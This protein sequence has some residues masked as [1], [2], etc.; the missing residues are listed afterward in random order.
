MDPVTISVV[1]G[2]LE[3]LGD[4]MDQ[5][6]IRAAISP[7]I[8]ETNDCAHGIFHPETGETI[9]QGRIGLPVFLANMQFT[10]QNVIAKANAA[11][12]FNPGDVWILNDPY[13]GGTHLPDVN[14][15]APHFVGDELVALFAN[16]GHW[17]DIGGSVPGGWA[18]KAKSIHEEGIIIPA[19]KL[20]DRGR[21]NEPLVEMFRANVRLP[22]QIVGD[23]SAMTNVFEL[24]RQGLDGLVARYGLGTIRECIDEMVVTSERQMRSYVA[25]IPDGV[26]CSEEWLDNDGIE[27]TP[28]RT[29]LRL[30]VRGDEMWLDFAGTARA[31]TGPMN[32]AQNTTLSTVYVALKHVFPEV[33]V[34]GGTFRPVHCSIP[35][36]S[37]LAAQYP[38]PVGGYLEVVSRVLDLVMSALAQAIPDKVPAASFGTTGVVTIGGHHPTTDAYFVGVFPYPGGYGGWSGGDGLV[39]GTPPQSMANFVSL[40]ASEHRYPIRFDHFAIREQSGGAGEHRGGCGTSYGFR[41]WGPCDMSVL[42]DRADHGPAGVAGG[43]DAAANSVRLIVDDVEWTPP[44]RTKLDQQALRAGDGINASSPGGAGWGDPLK[45]RVED[46]ESDLNLGYISA[47]DATADYGAVV[48]QVDSIAGHNRYVVDVEGTV[49][50]RLRRSQVPVIATEEVVV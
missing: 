27:D 48:A 50:E 23:L 42:G 41:A 5:H 38:S 34:N 17:M 39:N 40:E 15:V 32:L 24:G 13:L 29:R 47:A 16:T 30:E 8:S 18:P 26:Y 46:V 43:H 25:D 45:R 11:G 37:V 14:L 12:G 9:A 35:P 3:A 20:Y 21:L 1:R 31:A 33:P 6:L 49:A 7:I 10:V 2:A 36:G 4:E 19:V 22:D 28:L 44:L